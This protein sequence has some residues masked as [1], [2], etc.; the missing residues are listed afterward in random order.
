MLPHLHPRFFEKEQYDG[1]LP[2]KLIAAVYHKKRTDIQGGR[3]RAF[4]LKKAKQKVKDTKEGEDKGDEGDDGNTRIERVDQWYCF[5][6]GKCDPV[7]E[8]RV[9]SKDK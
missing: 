3:Y 7:E 5:A 4:V 8:N 1:K 9:I 6:K 2:F